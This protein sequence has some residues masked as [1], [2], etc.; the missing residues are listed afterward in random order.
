MTGRIS[1]DH[2]KVTADYEKGF[3]EN[4]GLYGTY[5][6]EPQERTCLDEVS[7]LYLGPSS[8]RFSK[9]H[10][11]SWVEGLGVIDNPAYRQ[12]S[13]FVI[14]RAKNICGRKCYSTHVPGVSVCELTDVLPDPIVRHEIS[15]PT[16]RDESE[17][18]VSVRKLQQQLQFLLISQRLENNRQ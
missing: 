17:R 18:G 8:I 9:N 5:V 2:G 10:N 14:K 11:G 7:S 1:I 13:G 6:W 16:T 12:I 4:H 3:L 15:I